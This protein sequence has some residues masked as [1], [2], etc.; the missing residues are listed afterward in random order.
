[1]AAKPLKVSGPQDRQTILCVHCHQPM[2]IGVHAMSAPCRHCG[3]PLLFE[4][5]H[6]NSHELK[7]RLLE[8]YGQIVVEKK[9]TCNADQIHCG[10]MV[11]HGKVN[12]HVTC[13][14]PVRVGSRAEIRGDVTAPAL[15]VDAGAILEGAYRIGTGPS[16]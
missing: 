8:T 7:R 12:G 3:K 6:I 16:P 2:E 9:G 14:G 1:M 11:V 15:A 13:D 5:I 10:G 4:D